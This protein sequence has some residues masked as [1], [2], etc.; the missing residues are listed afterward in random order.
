MMRDFGH[1]FKQDQRGARRLAAGADFF[2]LAF[3]SGGVTPLERAQAGSEP[4]RAGEQ[5]GG[6]EGKGV[7][8]LFWRGGG[9]VEELDP[10]RV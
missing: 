4:D 6:P 2:E 7:V 9:R 10:W 1:A 8:L 3:G 5:V